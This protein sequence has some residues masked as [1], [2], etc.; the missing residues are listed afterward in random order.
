M[1][2]DRVAA[3]LNTQTRLGSP[4]AHVALQTSLVGFELVAC[5]AVAL[6]TIWVGL[7][8][9]VMLWVGGLRM[10][11]GATAQDAL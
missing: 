5:L 2:G 10:S 4:S 11:L 3:R 6:K 7:F 8:D 1:D 9:G